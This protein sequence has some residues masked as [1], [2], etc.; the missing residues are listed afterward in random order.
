MIRDCPF[1]APISSL[2][3]PNFMLTFCPTSTQKNIRTPNRR[4]Y[5][6]ATQYQ[7][8]PKTY[9]VVRV[10]G[11][12]L[13]EDIYEETSIR[14][15]KVMRTYCAMFQ[16]A[17]WHSPFN[18][19]V[20]PMWSSPTKIKMKMAMANRTSRFYHAYGSIGVRPSLSQPKLLKVSTGDKMH[21]YFS[22]LHVFHVT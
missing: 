5:T 14:G 21:L 1:F 9:L 11:V 19:D 18:F 22:K 4:R 6:N 20:H 15:L 7:R 8:Y 16:D 10:R 2:V 17:P 13:H 12:I 3:I